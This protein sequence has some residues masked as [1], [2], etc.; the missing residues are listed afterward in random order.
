MYS[1]VYTNFFFF[2]FNIEGYEEFFSGITPITEFFSGISPITPYNFT[3]L[4]VFYGTL[5]T[6]KYKLKRKIIWGYRCNT[7]KEFSIAFYVK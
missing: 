2:L 5:T 7:T 6:V 3:L 4:F 1:K